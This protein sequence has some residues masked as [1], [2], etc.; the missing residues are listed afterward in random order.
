[1]K[2][3]LCLLSLSFTLPA[4]FA[5]EKYDFSYQ[6]DSEVFE[7]K[8]KFYVHLPQ[9]YYRDDQDSFGV[10]Y[11]L[12]AQEK[13]FYD[14]A[15][16]IIDYL[17]WNYEIFP[18]IVVGIHSE[19]RFKEFIP[20]DRSLPKEAEENIGQAEN[21][22]THIETEI[23]PQI[24][25]DFRPNEFRAI[26]GHSRGGA[27]LANTLFS[28]KKDLFN[29]YIGISPAMHFVNHQILD[30]AQSMIQE[31]APFHTFYF[32]SYGGLGFHEKY[33]KTQVDLLDSLFRTYPNSTID[34]KM[35]EMEG[36]THWSIVPSAV[37]QGI[38]EMNRAYGLDQFLIEAF[39]MQE[40]KP[41][42]EQ[43]LAYT[44]GQKKKLGYIQE[45]KSYHLRRFGDEF[46]EIQ[47]HRRALELYDL[48]LAKNMYDI[49][50]YLRKASVYRELKEQEK[51]ESV[52]K[53]ALKILEAN[54][55]QFSEAEI[56]QH[57]KRIMKKLENMR[58]AKN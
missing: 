21:L 36:K 58:N 9:D 24:A 51:A 11:I 5:Q 10:I 31:K 27:F 37:A 45:P 50:S 53:Q 35:R 2:T 33:F 43:I 8:R 48:A 42:A 12:D 26:L 41:M 40:D 16:G 52:Y 54:G 15:K 46:S 32:C 25:K 22:R 13:A 57:R 55:A 17:T 20:L 18:M 38:I 1:M 49:T 7:Q 34:W 19:N 44:K 30:D 3:L 23:F 39:A 6:I 14:N 56:Q 47:N 29:A 28:D 4:F